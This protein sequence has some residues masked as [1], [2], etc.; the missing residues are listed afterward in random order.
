M[1][2]KDALEDAV[3]DTTVDVSSLAWEARRAGLASRRRRRALGAV[4]VAAT[5]ALV[6]GVTWLALPGGGD[7]TAR[8]PARD[9]AFVTAPVEAPGGLSGRTGP[10]TGRGEVAALIASVDE[11]TEG[12]DGTYADFR[13][14]GGPEPMA[15]FLFTSD[16][17]PE[18]LVQLDLQPL[19]GPLG[20]YIGQPPYTCGET[21]M[22]ECT[23]VD[24]PGGDALRTYVDRVSGSDPGFQ[25]NVAEVISQARGLRLVLGATTT[26]QSET[27]VVRS[28]PPLT[29]AQLS[30]IA[31]Q[32]WWTLTSLPVE[33]LEEGEQLAS[34]EP[35]CR[36]QIE[37]DHTITTCGG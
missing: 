16:D 13:G 32:P 29:L 26:S 24:L 12:D 9:P 30:S 19:D 33:Y 5:L 27:D 25:R 23:V 18:G 11:V 2:L 7:D 10:V 31:S 3:A 17:A 20:D 21:Y 1:K 6:G 15:E 34:Y 36:D 35:L 28:E 8:D 37:D 4:G 14:T 22:R